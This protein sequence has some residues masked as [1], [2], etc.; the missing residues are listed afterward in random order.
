MRAGWLT[1]ALL[2]LCLLG[3]GAPPA[4]RAHGALLQHRLLPCIAIEALYDGGQP[5]AEAR[6]VVFAPDE[7]ARPWLTGQTDGQ[8]R[9]S[10]VPDPER[11]GTWSVQVRQAG[12]GAMIHIP[13]IDSGP[14]PPPH[15]VPA[16]APATAQRWL[17]ALAIVW[18]CLGTALFFLRRRP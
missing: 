8:G 16:P 4:L 7:P 9:F 3:L 1:G 15:P 11:P 12:H 10:F 5:M 2:L 6:V 13:L 14:V 17:M 18:G